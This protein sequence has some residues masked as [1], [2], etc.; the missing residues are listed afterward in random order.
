M[1]LPFTQQSFP[2]I[3]EQELVGALFRPFAEP[4]LDDLQLAKGQRLLDVACGT[5]IVARLA[6]ERLGRAGSVAGVDLNPGMLAVARQLAPDVDWREGDAASLPLG[7]GE[8]FDA[9]AC[10]QGFQFVADK[11]AAARQLRRALAPGGR[12]AV[13]TW[14]PD[15]EFPV[16][17]QLRQIAE[18]QVGAIDDRRHSCGEPGPLETLFKDAGCHEVRSKALKRTVRYPVGEVF[19][20]LNAMALVGMSAGAKGLNETDRER[21]VAAIVADSAPVIAS[22]TD[23]NGF[24]YE[25]GTN[26]MTARG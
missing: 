19:V 5:G 25:I 12:L 26:V 22:H 4:L 23:E 3:Y 14:R 24:A 8:Q 7:D 6:K 16:L 13:S 15:Q 2:E 17:Y 21:A 9:V 20:R 18:R 1:T 11:A 10:Q